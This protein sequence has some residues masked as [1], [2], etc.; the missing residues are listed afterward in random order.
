MVAVANVNENADAK[1]RVGV[2]RGQGM[3]GEPGWCRRKRDADVE[4]KRASIA[5]APAYATEG[6][7]DVAPW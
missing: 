2:E 5:A 4:R 1:N 6:E 3:D 7:R